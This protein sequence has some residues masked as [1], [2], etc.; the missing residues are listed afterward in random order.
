MYLSLN[1][2]LQPNISYKDPRPPCLC[3]Q[4]ELK[5]KE[6]FKYQHTKINIAYHADQ[7]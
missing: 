6:Y 2:L 3:V 4:R 5:K 1:I 7:E